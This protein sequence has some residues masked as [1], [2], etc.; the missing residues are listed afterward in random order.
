MAGYSSGMMT[1]SCNEDTMSSRPPISI[2]DVQDESTPG[3]FVMGIPENV[4]SMSSGW[5][6][7]DAIR[8]EET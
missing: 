5:I 8:P 2:G 6:T 1:D 7:S 3:H 4:I